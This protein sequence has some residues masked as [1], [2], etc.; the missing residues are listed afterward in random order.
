MG[1]ITAF[2]GE[3]QLGA[4]P[5][6]PIVLAISRRSSSV[7]HDVKYARQCRGYSNFTDPWRR[8]NWV[9]WDC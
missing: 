5:P 6:E 8:P 2:V 9:T 1:E 4:A 7:W 3:G